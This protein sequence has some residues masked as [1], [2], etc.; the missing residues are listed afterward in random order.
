MLLLFFYKLIK[1]IEMTSITTIKYLSYN[2]GTVWNDYKN[3]VKGSPDEQAFK[4]EVG[5]PKDQAIDSSLENAETKTKIFNLQQKT[6]RAVAEKIK[7]YD[8]ISFQEIKS[9]KRAVVKDLSQE[10][11]F[12]HL[13]S[14]PNSKS[15]CD[16]AI[17]IRKTLCADANNISLNSLSYEV[18]GKDKRPGHMGQDIAAITAPIKVAN[19]TAM[20]AFASMHTWGFKLYSPDQ[21]ERAYEK[22]DIS[23]K[24]CADAYAFEATALMHQHQPD[25]A[26]I[27]ADMNNNRE[28]YPRT[29]EQIEK[30]RFQVWE[31]DQE[32][33]VNNHPTEKDYRLRKIDF[34][35][36]SKNSTLQKIVQSIISIFKSTL[37]FHT[38]EAKVVEG[39]DFNMTDN[40]SDHKPITMTIT[41]QKV[42]SKLSQMAKKFSLSR[43]AFTL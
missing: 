19:K 6:E 40:C 28:N 13:P 36:T 38:T 43:L 31:P 12:Y 22:D 21:K 32:T 27:G 25:F 1:G 2:V 8:V 23:G 26:V 24:C 5:I 17:A 34:I 15:S 10:F 29:F 11:N 7:Q 42:P 4:Q 3:M 9:L 16:T 30:N 39:F 35:F 18:G 41:I 20:V 33:N 14:D 37:V